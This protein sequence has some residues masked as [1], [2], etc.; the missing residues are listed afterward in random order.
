MSLIVPCV[1][2][3]LILTGGR[4]S[5]IMLRIPIVIYENSLKGELLR[6]TRL[7]L[8]DEVPMQHRFAP[9]AIDRT[10]RDFMNQPDLPFGGITM[11]FG[12]DFQQT[13]P[14]IPKGTKEQIIKACIQRSQLWR[15]IKVLHFVVD[16]EIY[17]SIFFSYLLLF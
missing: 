10:L 4:T 8:W 11:V 15:H 7:I 12:G 6:K 3:S 13:L 9:E 17:F 2:S 1:A 5:H 16:C 14:I